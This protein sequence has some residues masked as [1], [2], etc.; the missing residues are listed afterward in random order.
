M[1]NC[2]ART[3]VA[4]APAHDRRVDG[5]HDRA[6]AALDRLVDERPR[7]RLVAEDVELEPARAPRRAATSAGVAVARV[8]SV[9]T[10]PAAA[11]ARDVATSPSGCA[12]R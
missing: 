10:V 8:E 5:E 1:S 4:L 12:T 2:E 6:E 7:H 9:I 3:K 11:A